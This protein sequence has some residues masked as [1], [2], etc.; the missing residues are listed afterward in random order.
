[1]KLVMLTMAVRLSHVGQEKSP[2]KEGLIHVV[3]AE[4]FGSFSG[5]PCA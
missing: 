4:V 2:R 1:M 3:V 5:S